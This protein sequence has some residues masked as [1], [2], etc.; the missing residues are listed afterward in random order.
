MPV[1]SSQANLKRVVNR[2]RGRRIAVVGDFMLDRYVWGEA[3]RLSPE[4][5]VPVVEFAEQNDCLGGAGNVA[6]NLAALGAR[7]LPFGIVGED[8]A[9]RGL[10]ASLAEKGLPDRGILSDRRRLTTMKTRVIAKHQQVVRVDREDRRPLPAALEK[11]LIARIKASLPQLDALVL[12]DYEK[13]VV[14]EALAEQVL[15][16]CRRRGLPAMVKPKTSR[17]FAY[18]GATAIVCNK[19]EAGYFVTRELTDEKSIEGAGRELLAYFGC[20]AVIIT[21]GEKGMTLFEES[22][23]RYVHIPA[24]SFEVSY[25]RVGLPGVD[26]GAGGRQVFDVTGA[27]DTVLSV[28]TLA[29]AARA[30]LEDALALANLAAGVVVGKLGTATVSPEELLRAIQDRTA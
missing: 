9:G 4:A 17:R 20:S 10:R 25:A 1:T 19:K 3:R 12:S 13:G 27:G 2:L 15:A 14:S 8:E 26:G 7:V 6:A 11:T 5:A 18:R 22:K 21:L 24:T 30:P 23:P 16:E 29:V 28:V